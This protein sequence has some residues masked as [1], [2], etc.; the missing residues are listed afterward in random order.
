MKIVPEGHR[1][2]ESQRITE[3]QFQ[4]PRV[5]GGQGVPE[6]RR[7]QGGQGVQKVKESHNPREYQRAKESK[8]C[9]LRESLGESQGIPVQRIPEGQRVQ[10]FQRSQRVESQN[11]S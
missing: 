1:V 6:F 5:P 7:V 11:P 9:S 2:T 4:N 8:Y 10:E 3:G